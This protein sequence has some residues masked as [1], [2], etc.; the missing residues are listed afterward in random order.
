MGLPFR[1]SLKELSSR[2]LQRFIQNDEKGHNSIE[3]AIA[4]LDLVNLKISKGESFG[5][6]GF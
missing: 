5:T 1:R 6:H 4:S 3:D 2:Y